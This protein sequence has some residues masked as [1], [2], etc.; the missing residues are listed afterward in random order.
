MPSRSYNDWRPMSWFDEIITPE[1]RKELEGCTR[2]ILLTL[3]RGTLVCRHI[4]ELIDQ[5]MPDA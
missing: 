5:R 3:L 1:E 2:Q 4:D